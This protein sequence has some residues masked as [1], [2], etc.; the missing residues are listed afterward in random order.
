L[1][2]YASFGASS[3]EQCRHDH[4]IASQIANKFWM[5]IVAVIKERVMIVCNSI[6]CCSGHKVVYMKA[7]QNGDGSS[8]V[9]GDLA[10]PV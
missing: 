9:A 1:W 2:P 8:V 10:L 4:D 7:N 5:L 3:D 6:F